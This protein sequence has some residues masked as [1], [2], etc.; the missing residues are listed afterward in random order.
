MK[1]N[2]PE[3][4]KWIRKNKEL[5]PLGVILVVIGVFL[6][7]VANSISVNFE[8]NEVEFTSL[9]EKNKKNNKLNNKYSYIEMIGQPKLISID[10]DA[11]ENGYFIIE[12]D[13][14]NYIIYGKIEEFSKLDVDSVVKYY[15]RTSSVTKILSKIII[16]D[17]NKINSNSLVNDGNFYDNFSK[18]YLD[19]LSKDSDQETLT[20]VASFISIFVGMT[21]I[22]VYPLQFLFSKNNLKNI[23][24]MIVDELVKYIERKEYTAYAKY[25]IMLFKKYLM[26]P[27]ITSK[28]VRI[29][30]I[31]SIK[32]FYS[33]D[34]VY[35]IIAKTIDDKEVCIAQP[36]ARN[37]EI[38]FKFYDDIKLLNKIITI[39]EFDK[40]DKK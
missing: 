28:I 31:V 1:L 24:P 27:M 29:E 33:S 36:V 35:S 7:Y 13:D 26:N 38:L 40:E 8:K 12:L 6:I 14:F 32:E 20:R 18:I 30:D 2:I 15:G 5:I 4:N 21:F 17:Y 10:S 23:D 9:V 16:D 34:G 37:K 3:F 22:L 39:E 11:K 25:H 19:T